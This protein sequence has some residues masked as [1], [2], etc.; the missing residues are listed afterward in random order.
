MSKIEDLIKQHCPNGVEYK[1]LDNILHSIRTGLNPRQNF[2][3]N[4]SGSNCYYLTVK[5]M[6]TGHIVFTS[7]TDMI[8]MKFM[9]IIKMEVFQNHKSKKDT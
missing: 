2:K 6:T 5:E 9:N 3:L 7:K 8:S 1:T 4:E